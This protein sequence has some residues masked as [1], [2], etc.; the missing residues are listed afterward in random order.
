VRNAR[1]ERDE[2]GDKKIGEW[3]WF[4]N[5]DAGARELNGLRT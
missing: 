3:K 4:D 2:K 5:P 1:L